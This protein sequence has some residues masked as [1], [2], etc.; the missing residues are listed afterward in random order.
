MKLTYINHSGFAIEG[1]HCTIIID[2][3]KDSEDEYIKKSLSSFAGKLYVCS[4]HWHPD[5][6]NRE[7]LRWKTIR[8]DITYIFSDDIRKKNFASPED[9]TFLNKGDVLQDESIHIKAFGSTD[10]GIS[11]LIETEGKKIFHAGD[12]NNW[13]WDEESTPD[14]IK[15]AE[16]AFLEELQ[17]LSDET[18]HLDLALFPVDCRLGKNYMRGAEQFVDAIQTDLFAPMHFGHTYREA[19]AFR[20][21]AEKAGCKF[22]TWTKTGESILF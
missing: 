10:V 16:L 1:V 5:H 21:Y 8:P 6:F 15:E 3:F 9:A 7:I 13:H 17:A 19:N 20:P 11:F 18:G 22:A 14:E 2:Y 12:L 4:S